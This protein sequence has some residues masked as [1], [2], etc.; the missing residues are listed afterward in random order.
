MEEVVVAMRTNCGC[1]SLPPYREELI[2]SVSRS[3]TGNVILKRPTTDLLDVKR[4]I[5][6]D[7]LGVLKQLECGIQPD[8]EIILEGISLIEIQDE[9]GLETFY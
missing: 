6:S 2:K 9:I 7:T 5:I 1:F 3:S 4:K 8:L